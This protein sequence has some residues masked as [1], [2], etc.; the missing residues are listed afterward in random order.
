ML[1]AGLELTPKHHRLRSQKAR[2][3]TARGTALDRCGN[4]R[5]ALAAVD[6]AVTVAE[7]LTAEDPS[8]LYD[9]GCALAL[10]AR[11]N[12]LSPDRP[13]AAVAALRKAV[14]FGFDNVYK[15]KNDQYLEPIR[16][17]ED[18]QG[19][20]SDAEKKAVGPT[21]GQRGAKR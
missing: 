8:Y 5:G 19:L 6:Q 7:K 1:R 18:F 14:D 20:V 11:L 15:L 4:R 9:L 21:I 16:R 12:G 3:E 10:K 17:R 2:L 13:A